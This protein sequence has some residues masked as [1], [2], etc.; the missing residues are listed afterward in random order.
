[1]KLIR[2]RFIQRTDVWA[3]QWYNAAK[4]EG[5]YWKVVDGECNHIPQCQ[6]RK[7]CE[8]ITPVPLSPSDVAA[9]LEK[10]IT[11]G[12]YQLN[13]EGLV[14]WLCFDV[15]IVK[16][17]EGTEE[18]VRQRTRRLAQRLQQLGIPFLVESSGHRGYHVWVFSV[19]VQ[20]IK[21]QALGNFVAE[22]VEPVEGIGIEVF[23]K[24]TQV[25]TVGNLVKLPLG[26][27]QRT[28]QACY[29]VR[30][31]WQSYD[32]QYAALR[33]VGE[34]T[35]TQID[36][37]LANYHVPVVERQE[38]A[39]VG[40]MTPPCMV[41]LMNEGVHEGAKD[42][43]T[44]RLA[45]YLRDRG[46]SYD[47]AW[48]AL[49]EWNDAHGGQLETERL[50]SKLDSAYGGNYSFFPCQHVEMDHYC[51]PDCKQYESKMKTRNKK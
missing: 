9:H 39:T 31:N 49:S 37:L 38:N 40:K 20:A 25:K 10:K 21:M 16:G 28:K 29:F 36:E 11:I 42:V 3:K 22:S 26:I 13:Q 50:R 48:A 43:P 35:E 41:N 34:L 27:H 14:K 24:Q 12:V 4:G 46:L 18:G 8:S 33:D 17:G 5:G 7:S 23:P 6:P 47:M 30:P 1:M 19:P 44:F 45:C 51:Q 15:D 2:H 32:D